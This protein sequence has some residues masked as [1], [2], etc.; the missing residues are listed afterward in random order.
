MD[1]A[2]GPGAAPAVAPPGTR[3]VEVQ[4]PPGREPGREPGRVLEGSAAKSMVCFFS[5]ARTPSQILST[6][7]M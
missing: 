3:R 6:N 4:A 1:G 7:V 2:E 5:G